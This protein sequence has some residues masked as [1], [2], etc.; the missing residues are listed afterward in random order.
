[1]VSSILATRY[2]DIRYVYPKDAAMTRHIVYLI[3]NV[4]MPL[5]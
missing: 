3:A 1:M 2:S 4:L 5:Y